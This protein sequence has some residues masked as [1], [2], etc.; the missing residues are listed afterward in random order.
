MAARCSRLGKKKWQITTEATKSNTDNKVKGMGL[1]DVL[2]PPF[3]ATKPDRYFA[4]TSAKYQNTVVRNTSNA[5]AMP[6]CCQ[7]V[8]PFL[9]IRSKVW[10]KTASNA[11]NATLIPTASN[12]AYPQAE[13]L[14]R[15]IS[16]SKR[17]RIPT[18]HHARCCRTDEN[19]TFTA[20]AFTSF[21]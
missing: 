5:I 8:L 3:S 6:R 14:G 2:P 19:G 4:R 13:K 12:R 7:T 20:C 16:P 18:A 17:D 10:A 15:F 9:T 11:A 1:N 21:C